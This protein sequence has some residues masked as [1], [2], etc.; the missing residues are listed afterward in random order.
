[1]ANISKPT[2]HKFE[3]GNENITLES[4]FAILKVLGL[5]NEE[6]GHPKEKDEKG[7]NS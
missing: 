1:M 5:L 2:V 3:Q 4:A 7:L 6:G